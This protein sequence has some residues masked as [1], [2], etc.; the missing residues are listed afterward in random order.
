MTCGSS[1]AQETSATPRVRHM[2]RLALDTLTRFLALW[3]LCREWRQRVADR[4]HLSGLDDHV[5]ADFGLTRQ[6]VIEE[7]AKP[8]WEPLDPGSADG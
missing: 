4:R 5:L 8:F 1:G 3:Q 7:T 2:S 6:Q